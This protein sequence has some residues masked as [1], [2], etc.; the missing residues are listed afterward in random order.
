MESSMCPVCLSSS[1]LNF[2]Y[3]ATKA[4]C[5]ACTAAFTRY[6]EN[7][8]PLQCLRNEK[9]CDPSR[10]QEKGRACRKCRIDR[11]KEIGMNEE[12][13]K[14]KAIV[15]IP[16]L[17]SRPRFQHDKYPLMSQITNGLQ[18]F[19]RGLEHRYYLDGKVSRPYGSLMRHIGD[20]GYQGLGVEFF[21]SYPFPALYSDPLK[22]KLIPKVLV[23]ILVNLAILQVRGALEDDAHFHSLQKHR[24]LQDA[25]GVQLPD[26]L[27]GLNLFRSFS[28]SALKEFAK[29]ITPYFVTYYATLTTL[30]KFTP[31][32][33]SFQAWTILG[34]HG[35]QNAR[36]RQERWMTNNR[37]YILSNVYYESS[38]EAFYTQAKRS[39]PRATHTDWKNI[40]DINQEVI[41]LYQPLREMCEHGWYTDEKLMYLLMYLYFVNAARNHSSVDVVRDA[42]QKLHTCIMDEMREYFIE[43]DKGIH[44]TINAVPHYMNAVQ[45]FQE[46][47]AHM[48]TYVN[49]HVDILKSTQ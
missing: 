30:L 11:C 1:P 38:E 36:K 47:V 8:K 32:K 39:L 12:L 9:F 6:V 24:E 27:A 19:Y 43:N 45:E 14:P 34:F 40:A 33:L 4:N 22:Y 48:K 20:Q 16:A 3:G 21:Y 25:V 23:P 10:G 28:D 7:K 41:D 49:L 46:V 26:I 2:H 18:K 31:L 13:V 5:K 29:P 42:F 15:L 35:F 17:T 44:F 37:S